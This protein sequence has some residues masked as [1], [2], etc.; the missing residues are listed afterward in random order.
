[1]KRR[2]FLKTS[3]SAAVLP[4]ALGGFS[5]RAFGRSPIF[6]ALT[7]K[8]NCDDRVLV[9]VQL[10]GG[11]DG[12]NTVIPIDQYDRYVAARKNI[13]I[14]ENKIL[15]LTTKTG[16]NPELEGLEQLYK[17]GKLCIIQNAGYPSPNFSHFRSVDIWTSASEYDQYVTTGW[18]GRYLENIYPHY[19]FGYPT[20]AVP[21]P[22]AI[23]VGPLISPVLDGTMA[24]LG[25]SFSNPASYYDINEFASDNP[26]PQSIADD[27]LNH[28]KTT[29]D[30]ISKFAVPV[31]T[32]A[33][34]SSIRSKRWPTMKNPLADQL[35]IVAQLIA[36][37]LKTKVYIV[38]LPGFDTHSSQNIDAG[39]TAPHPK[40]LWYLSTAI[41]AFQDD[42]KLNG[43]EDRVLGMTFSEFGRRIISNSAAGTDHGTA[44]PLFMF[45]SSVKG[46]IVG[47]NPVLP[48]KASVEDN[49]AM[50][51]DFRQVYSTVLKDWFCADESEIKKVL[52]KDF[53]PLPVI[54]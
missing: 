33:S 5:V 23:Q 52:F 17:E 48:E 37:G 45:G 12:L 14:E 31:K 47:N 10:I 32:A 1:M 15:K 16:L 26:E 40:L 38:S 50:T 51:V 41:N 9:L 29:G 25:M 7:S 44:A 28:I 13:A 46:G 19:P 20:A 21:D 39:A 27:Y 36:G 6:D 8:A 2:D 22:A 24:N 18:L 11:N 4:F 35:K 49:V 42:L 43:L 53:K 30:Q 34:K 3:G 54:V